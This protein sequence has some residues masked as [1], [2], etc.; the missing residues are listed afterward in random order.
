MYNPKSS[1]EALLW[2]EV[3]KVLVARGMSDAL[4]DERVTCGSDCDGLTWR[5]MYDAGGDRAGEVEIGFRHRDFNAGG[6]PAAYLSIGLADGSRNY[7]QVHVTDVV[8]MVSHL[9]TCEVEARG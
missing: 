9:A 1:F 3:R 4:V 2:P 5:M 8:A 6:S 7:A